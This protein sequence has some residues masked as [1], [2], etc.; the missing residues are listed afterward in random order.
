MGVVVARVIMGLEFDGNIAQL[1]D[2]FWTI[3][4]IAGPVLLAA[5]VIGLLIGILQAAT[6]INEMTL[7]FV[8]KIL[9]VLIF[10]AIFSSFMMGGLAE[11][12]SGIFEEIA[13]IR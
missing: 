13:N 1:K 9:L 3:V 5:L 2:A 4:L 12:F 7:S 6:S 10:L 8:P 11:Y